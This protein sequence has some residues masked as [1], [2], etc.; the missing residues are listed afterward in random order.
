MT[1]KGDQSRDK[2][3]KA[4]KALDVLPRL[5]YLIKE[6]NDSNIEVQAKKALQQLNE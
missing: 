4:L 2:R 5:E 1:W 3:K 6:S